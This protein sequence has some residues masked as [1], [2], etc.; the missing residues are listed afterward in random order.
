MSAHDVTRRSVLGGALGLGVAAG[1]GAVPITQ[2]AA[3]ERAAGRPH[4]DRKVVLITG[5][6]SGFGYLTALTLA[7][8]GHWVFASMRNTRTSNAAARRELLTVAG[9]EDLDLEVID[10]DVRREQSVNQAV[11]RVLRR[12]RRID[13]LYNNA[14]TFS[15][16][17]L[18]TLTIDDIKESFET[19]LFGHLRLN[20]AV[21]PA[22]REQ[23]EGLVVQMTTALGRFVLPFMGP[24]VGAKWAL[25]AMTESSRYELSRFGVEFVIVEPGAYRTNFL[26]PNGQRYY[27]EYLRS[28][29]RDNARRRSEYGELAERAEAHLALGRD[30]LDSHEIADAIASVV[31]APRG[32]RPLRLVGPGMEPFLDELNELTEGVARGAMTGR[33][34]DDLLELDTGS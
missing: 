15:P 10:L 6:S 18:E 23:R 3:S 31:R 2:A 29:S 12:A 5:S 26:E 9:K 19:N 33:G 28:L 22:M 14:G 27:D 24:Y 32:E 21:L 17:V 13:V 4:P 16:A 34:W 7:R 30:S 25:E 1:L 8:A 11:S 20:R